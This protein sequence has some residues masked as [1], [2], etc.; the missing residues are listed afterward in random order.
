MADAKISALTAL[1]GAQVDT[2]ADLLAIVDTSAATTK[3]IL[4]SEFQIAINNLGVANQ[5]QMETASTSTV[6]VAPSV[7]HFHPGSAKAWGYI[8]APNTVSASYPAT[9]VSVVKNG[10][11]DYTITHGRVFSSAIYPYFIS[12]FN[13][14]AFWSQQAISTDS[15]R[16]NTMDNIGNS[17]D[18]NNIFY[19]V[20]G[21]L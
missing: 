15:F 1:S 2:A 17:A 3:K 7:Q 4:V 8:T 19:V 9:G 6:A 21:D 20:Y 10:V 12:I 18:P 16:I 11:G 14:T 13:G 5:A